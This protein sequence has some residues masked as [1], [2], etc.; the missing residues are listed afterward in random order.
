[1]K[2]TLLPILIAGLASYSVS[3]NDGTAHKSDDFPDKAVNHKEH[4]QCSFKQQASEWIDN[5]RSST[6]G[7]LCNSIRWIDGL[8]GNEHEF[9]DE[10]FRGKVSIGFRQDEDHGLDPR[11]R[12]KLRTKLPNVSNRFN[13]FVG[14]VEEDS[15]ISNTE[16]D[17]NQLNTVGLRSVDD[18]DP[19]WLVG[20]GYR[21]PNKRDNGFDFSIGAKLSSGLNPYAKL[22][23]RYVY[24]PDVK[25][26]WKST[27]TLFWRQDE[28]YG[29][30]SNLDYI[31][32]LNDQDI[33][34]W[35]IGAKY[36]EEKEQWEWITS[37]TWH[38]SFNDKKGFT[39][40][41]Y[42]R[43]EEKSPVSIPEFGV[44]F[45]YIRP[46]LRPWLALETGIDFRWEKELPED[47]YKS[48][49]RIGFQ[50]EMQLGEYY[51]HERRSIRD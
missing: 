25:N 49:T 20:I 39:T 38:H 12:V 41:S 17:K 13:A 35:D 21:N 14:R 15:F 5:L 9:N 11:L 45:S 4:S 33:L 1:M 42:V 31:H 27:Q 47:E 44:T 46:F 18:D 24:S 37:G 19:E 48:N 23:H 22:A 29:F 3:A 34:K 30:S 51:K 40:R 50:F 43:G 32:L 16:V 6:H 8:F 7:G 26:F 36:T 28:G 2:N 10:D